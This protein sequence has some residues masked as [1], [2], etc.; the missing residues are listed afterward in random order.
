M[1]GA[2]NGRGT[3]L[4]CP[5]RAQIREALESLG[6]GPVETGPLAF[7]TCELMGLDTSVCPGS[8]ELRQIFS[9]HGFS[10]RLEAMRA[11]GDLVA[12]PLTEWQR[13]SGGKVFPRVVRGARLAYATTQAARHVASAAQGARTPGSD[14]LRELALRIARERVLRENAELVERYAQEWL[15]GRSGQKGAGDGCDD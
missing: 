5:S 11:D 6:G 8:Y 12:R 4:P 13:L 3:K 1:R 15:D 10:R 9:W 2:A 7:R 14:G